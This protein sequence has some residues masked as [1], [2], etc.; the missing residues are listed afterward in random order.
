MQEKAAKRNLVADLGRLE[1]VLA[2]VEREAGVGELGQLAK[3]ALVGRDGEVEAGR[4]VH[5]LLERSR[6]AA[7]QSGVPI[8]RHQVKTDAGPA[9]DDRAKEQRTAFVAG[10]TRFEV[11][12]ASRVGIDVEMALMRRENVLERVES[13][14]EIIGAVRRQ[15]HRRWEPG[16]LCHSAFSWGRR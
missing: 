7:T 13:V 11:V 9:G 16:L 10:R 4:A 8:E 14:R 2:F 15:E 6:D 5:V 3:G 1:E 12:A